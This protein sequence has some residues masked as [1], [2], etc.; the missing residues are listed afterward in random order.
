MQ[1]S[2]LQRSYQVAIKLS[3]QGDGVLI[4][5]YMFTCWFITFLAEQLGIVYPLEVKVL[6]EFRPRAS[7]YRMGPLK[8]IDSRH[9]SLHVML[10][11]VYPSTCCVIKMQQ[12]QI[13]YPFENKPWRIL[14][15]LQSET[16]YQMNIPMSLPWI[17]NTRRTSGNCACNCNR[18]S[19]VPLYINTFSSEIKPKKSW[20]DVVKKSLNCKRR[21]AAVSIMA[22][23]K[24]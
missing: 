2:V 18:R 22:V 21:N 17:L 1:H 24:A 9:L 7:S 5:Q 19:F 15:R 14:Y 13:F 4:S 3:I 6:T 16:S 12:V 8:E 20:L 23:L 11:C 10:E